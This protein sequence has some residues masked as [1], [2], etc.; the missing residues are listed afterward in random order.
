MTFGIGRRDFI[1]LLGGAAAAWPLAAGAQQQ[2]MPVI[3]FLDPRSPHTLA[4]Q[5]RAS[6]IRS[7]RS[8]PRHSRPWRSAAACA[9]APA[10]RFPPQHVFVQPFQVCRHHYSIADEAGLIDGALFGHCVDLSVSVRRPASVIFT[11]AIS[12]ARLATITRW[13]CAVAS[14]ARTSSAIWST[15]KPCASS[16]ASVQPSRQEASSSSARRRSGLGPRR[17]GRTRLR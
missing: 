12:T 17:T 11:R 16:I 3:G 5:L 15:V 13:L 2:A 4:D 6:G 7:P 9:P 1:T 10:I 8:R 14:P